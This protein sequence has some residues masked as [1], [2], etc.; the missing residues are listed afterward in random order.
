MFILVVAL[1]ACLRVYL[2]LDSRPLFTWKDTT[3]SQ[4]FCQRSVRSCNGKTIK[5]IWTCNLLC[6]R[7]ICYHTKQAADRNLNL[8]QFMLQK[9]DFLNLL[10]SMNAVPFWVNTQKYHKAKHFDI[11]YFV[12]NITCT[13]L[14]VQCWC[15]SRNNSTW[16]NRMV[17]LSTSCADGVF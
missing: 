10:N 12:I 14:L 9:S 4:Q 8:T 6:K 5:I 17:K 15:E 11:F 7:P 1:S 13:M 16:R 3:S 2:G